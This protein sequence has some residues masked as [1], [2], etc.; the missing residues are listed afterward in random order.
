M[1]LV[2][3]TLAMCL[4]SFMAYSLL[5][6]FVADGSSDKELLSGYL[7]GTVMALLGAG[8]IGRLTI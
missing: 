6:Q 3:L 1:T 7:I 5:C 8:L 2:F 4:M